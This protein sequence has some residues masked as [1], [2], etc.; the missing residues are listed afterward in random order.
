MITLHGNPRSTQWCYK[1][2]C[3]GK[4]ATVYMSKPCKE[5]KASYTKEVK[6][7]WKKP[8]ILGDVGLD[9]KLYFGDK[10]KRDV[11]NFQKLYFDSMSKI[12]FEDDSQIQDLRVR[13]YY[14]KDNPR[15]IIKVKEL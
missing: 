3:R 7:Q 11:D 14:D 6:E 4:F 1:S 10:R 12:V 13:K 2:T 15:V 9:V 8:I 5:L